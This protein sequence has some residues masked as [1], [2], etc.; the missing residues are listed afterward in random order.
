MQ[1][2]TKRGLLVGVT[3]V[4]LAATVAAGSAVAAKMD[5]ARFNMIV[6]PG[7][8]QCLPHARGDVK[9]QSLGPVEVMRVD[10]EGLPANTNFDFFVI[11]IPIAPFGVSWYQGD[12]ET[13]RKG[14]GSQRFIGR[15]NIE[16]F[17]VSPDVAAPPQVHTNAPFPDATV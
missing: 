1:R 16:T 6:S 13:N 9:I 7:A 10:V 15:F 2:W 12:I 3:G 5:R 4:V 14:E 11:Q 8:A 17:A